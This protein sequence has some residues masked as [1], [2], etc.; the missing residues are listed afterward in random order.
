MPERKAVVRDDVGLHARPAATFVKE[1]K[2]FSSEI[3]VA[4]RGKRANAK[5][6]LEVLM[7]DAGKGA[8]VTLAAEGEDAEIALERLVSLLIAGPR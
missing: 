1:A 6:I 5:S 7:L 8:E 3:V 4:Y 2:S